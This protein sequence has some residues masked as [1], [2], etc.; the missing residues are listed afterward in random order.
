M[1]VKDGT[2]SSQLSTMDQNNFTSHR[3]PLTHSLMGYYYTMYYCPR[4]QKP[5]SFFAHTHT[6][7]FCTPFFPIQMIYSELTL[8]QH[9]GCTRLHSPSPYNSINYA[10]KHL[11]PLVSLRNISFG[12]KG[13]S[14]FHFFFH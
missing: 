9:M 14:F 8:A 10:A 12:M 13:C 1:V 5:F 3:F 7:R 11:F 6:Q 2:S 4:I